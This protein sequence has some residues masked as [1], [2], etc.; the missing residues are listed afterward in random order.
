MNES[1][2]SLISFLQALG[3]V[4]Y[5]GL[6]AG[7]FWTANKFFI[8]Q[9]SFWQAALMLVLLVFSVAIVGS[10]IFGYAAYLALNQRIKD[11]LLLVIYT[12]LFCVAM[13]G[14]GLIVF[15]VFS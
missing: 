13:F 6:V 5:C 4:V 2:L 12:S 1:K 7:F 11:A 14:I 3:V 8:S 10:L 15:V 9:P